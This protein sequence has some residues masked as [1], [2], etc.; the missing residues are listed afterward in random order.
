L[1]ISFEEDFNYLKNIKL[2]KIDDDQIKIYSNKIDKM[3]NILNTCLDYEIIKRLQKNYYF[4]SVEILEK[5]FPKKKICT[6]T[7]NFL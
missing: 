3:G 6:I 5:L 4:K 7:Q 2:D 1:I